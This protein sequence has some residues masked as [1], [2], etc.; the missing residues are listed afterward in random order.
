MRTFDRKGKEE[1][2]ITKR[3]DESEL[4]PKG[5]NPVQEVPMTKGREGNSELGGDGFLF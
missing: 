5:L 3:T 1:W 2:T 4:R